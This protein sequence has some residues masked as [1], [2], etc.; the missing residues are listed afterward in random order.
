VRTASQGVRD[1]ALG[2]G[3]PG[4]T[5]TSCRVPSMSRG[6]QPLWSAAG[7]PCTSTR[8]GWRGRSD[9]FG[10][11]RTD[12]VSVPAQR[13]THAPKLTE[14]CGDVRWSGTF[15]PAG[16]RARDVRRRSRPGL[17]PAACPRMRPAGLLVGL[18]HHPRDPYGQQL[19]HRPCACPAI[20]PWPSC[21]RRL[22]TRRH[23]GSRLPEQP[24]Y[25]SGI[26]VH[27]SQ[28]AAGTPQQ[29]LR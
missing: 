27:Q 11:P 28:S 22:P 6:G 23:H 7:R 14:A 17:E 25:A 18:A 8:R 13:R 19:V 2:R 20:P 15:H 29:L 3:S 9:L 12:P 26:R 16:C 24:S 1:Q 10:I 21:S 5:T 4:D